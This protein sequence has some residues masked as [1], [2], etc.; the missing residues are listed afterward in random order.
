M[1]DFGPGGLGPRAEEFEARE[2]DDGLEEHDAAQQDRRLAQHAAGAPALFGRAPCPCGGCRG[3]CRF[4]FLLR[5]LGH[6]S[7]TVPSCRRLHKS[8]KDRRR[9][10]DLVSIG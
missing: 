4:R 7:A 6:G 8:D 2:E 1:D 3:R 5:L 9:R 10:T